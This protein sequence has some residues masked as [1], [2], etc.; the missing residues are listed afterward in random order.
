MFTKHKNYFSIY[1]VI[2]LCHWEQSIL[3]QSIKYICNDKEASLV[4]TQFLVKILHELEMV[5]QN[6]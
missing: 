1:H 5:F 3:L 6:K 2:P 4:K